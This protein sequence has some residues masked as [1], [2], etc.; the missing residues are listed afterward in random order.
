MTMT[1]ED[2]KAMCEHEK[3]EQESEMRNRIKVFLFLSI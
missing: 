1:L 2:R 3:K